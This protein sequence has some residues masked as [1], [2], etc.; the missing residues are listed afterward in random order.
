MA[1]YD[2]SMRYATMKF[3]E[4]VNP[5][6]HWQGKD[7]K[8]ELGRVIA[9]PLVCGQNLNH[10]ADFVIDRTTHWN[11]YY[12]C[13]AQQALNSQM[14]IVNNSTAFYAFDKHVCY[15]LL[16]R[17]MHPTD[18]LPTTVLLP[19]YYPWNE[20]LERQD[21]WEYEQKLI[22]Q[23]TKFGFD[24][25]R[26]HTDWKKVEEK[27]KRAYHGER[28][29]KI[30]R[31]LFY[32]KG[33]YL[34]DVVE[35]YFHNHFPMYL[36]KVAGGGG[37]DV[38]KINNIEELYQKYD[39]TGGRA[40]HLQ[41]AVENY[42][43]FIRCLALGPQ[44]MPMKFLPDKPLHEHYAPEKISWDDKLLGTVP[45]KIN[46]DK[47]ILKRMLNYVMFINSY[48]RWTYNSFEAFI[49]EGQVFPIDFANACPDSNFTSLHV[50]FPWLICSKLRWFAYCAVTGK[51][52][53]VDLEQKAYLDVLNNPNISQEEKYQFCARKSVDYFEIE[54]FK[55]FCAENFA[56]LN[57]K[58]VQFYDRQFEDIISY[59]IHFSDFPEEEHE[60][61]YYQYKNMMETYFRPNAMEYLT[62]PEIF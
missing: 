21:M 56:D 20:D 52:M 13:W 42:D 33:N 12:K 40:F 22:I 46:V 58:M 6:I 55:A 34:K 54:P 19:Q 30:V 39:E 15:D 62:A 48:F 47:E 10:V 37:S 53:R 25:R 45:N 29:G 27:L 38:F 50:H 49:K 11:D 61:F 28:L 32:A 5:V 31:D 17:A 14:S 57:Q 59:A 41:E 44:I 3:L 18:R 4:F 2:W 7:Y 16:A 36:K 1:S 51:D 35:K 23:H 24:E 26:R 60:K 8:L 9:E 43:V